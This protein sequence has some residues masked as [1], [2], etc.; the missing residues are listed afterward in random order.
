VSRGVT[1]G[2]ATAICAALT[3]LAAPCRAQTPDAQQCETDANRRRAAWA[4]APHSW[5]A[6]E[7]EL[8]S[9]EIALDLC[10]TRASA[11]DEKMQNGENLGRVIFT[12]EGV[13]PVVGTIAPGNGLA[14]GVAL[15]HASASQ[16]RALRFNT[17]VETRASMNGSWNAGAAL[18]ILG[19]SPTRTN[20]H[21]HAEAGVE[22]WHI[23]QLSYFGSGNDTSPDETQFG[24]DRTLGRFTVE[25]A[26]TRGFSVFGQVEGL[27]ATTR[28]TGGSG[29][30]VEQ[31][32]SDMTAPGLGQPTA[33][34]V[35]GGGVNWRYPQDETLNGY[36]VGVATAVR[37]Y[38]ETAGRPYS[39]TRAEITWANQ[40]T[41]DTNV[42]LGTFSAALR[43]IASAVSGGDRV[44]FYLQP[45]LGGTD[46]NGEA[47]LR[48]YHD[49]RFR[50]PDVIAARFEY[51]RA[52]HDP[53]G[54][55]VFGDD[56]KVGEEIR[57]LGLSDLK[58]SFGVGI[59]LRAG[60]V[61]YL[62][63]Y[64]AW[65]GGEGSHTNFSG[66]SN[67]L[68]PDGALRGVF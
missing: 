45:T 36:S 39:F 65:G 8:E 51:T 37:R 35:S 28:S 19:S 66:S 1:A 46:I 60:N 49:Y 12:G 38:A 29:T 15:N 50:A 21:A 34:F 2:A 67:N 27:R 5:L 53:L 33:Y 13:H 61:A 9:R 26:A 64:Y 4:Q 25:S 54:L 42:D 22:H 6:N 62:Q 56:G 7:L 16:S 68:A 14:G 47:G 43:V 52:I 55:L 63:L 41:P 40:Y 32:F 30:P 57:D 24:L 48:S 44:P 20:H 10:R 17:R 58:H 31:R 59:T 18:S 23:R 11:G 3:V